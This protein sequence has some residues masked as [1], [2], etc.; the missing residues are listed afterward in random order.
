MS[1]KT[2]ICH[3]SFL[4]V[5]VEVGSLARGRARYVD[6]SH[7]WILVLTV[8]TR[9]PG[10][11]GMRILCAGTSIEASV[12]NGIERA[13]RKRDKE[14]EILYHLSDAAA[15]PAAPSEPLLS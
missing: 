7:T 8:D 2:K 12:A 10:K 14:L 15:A 1:I 5:D 6:G 9:Y 13:I 4:P 3:S 11:G